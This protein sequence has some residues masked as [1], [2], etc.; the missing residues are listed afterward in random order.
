MTLFEDTVRLDDPFAKCAY[1]MVIKDLMI[2]PVVEDEKAV[3][4]VRLVD[5]FERIAQNLC[6]DQS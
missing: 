1:L 6:L 5:V 2:L 4:V 3:G